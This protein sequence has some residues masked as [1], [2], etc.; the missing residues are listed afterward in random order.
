MIMIFGRKATVYRRSQGDYLI[1]FPVISFKSKRA[2]V[3]RAKV[4]RAKVLRELGVP[5]SLVDQPGVK[6]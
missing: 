3:L 5:R 6:D 2:K 1:R 4:L